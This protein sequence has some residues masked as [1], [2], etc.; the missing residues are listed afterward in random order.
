M[1]V[2]HHFCSVLCQDFPVSPNGSNWSKGE[3]K[4]YSGRLIPKK[5]IRKF[6]NTLGLKI[7]TNLHYFSLPSPLWNML[8]YGALGNNAIINNPIFFNFPL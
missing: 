7:A 3:Y 2:G 4:K 5:C 8:E 1:Y 6:T